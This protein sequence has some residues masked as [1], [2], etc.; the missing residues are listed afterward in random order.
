MNTMLAFHPSSNT[1]V[2]AFTNVFGNFNEH[3]FF[4]NELIPAIL[5]SKE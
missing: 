2:V 3:D 4:I 1:L 5:A